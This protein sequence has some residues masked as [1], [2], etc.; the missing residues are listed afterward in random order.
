MKP[1]EELRISI[2]QAP[3]AWADKKTNLAYFS[4]E[5]ENLNATPD[6]IILPE[7][8][9]T[10]FV[11]DPAEIAEPMN[12]E[13]MQW[14]A[15]N[16]TR[17]GSVIT[18]SVAIEEDGAYYN[19][20]IWMNPDGSF[21]S[22]DKRHLF[23]MGNEHLLFNSGKQPLL[24]ELNGWKIRPLICYD[25]RFPVWSK[26]RMIKEKYEYD[27][28]IYV[29][30]WP[31][32]RGYVWKSLLIARAIENQAFCI[33][34]NRI[35]EDGKGIPHNGNSL[36]LDFKGRSLMCGPTNEPF[37]DTV[38]LDYANLASFRDRFAVGLD[39]DKFS[40]HP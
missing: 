10:A 4:Q 38:V 15:E 35:G 5:L 9:S 36:V 12:G 6:L 20:L 25:L 16:A 28:L 19:R 14:M 2:I 22:S 21:V 27:L 24:V 3:L 7:M 23:R 33:G 39:W 34:V 13:T 30:N 8:F 26:N 18:G 31:A 32:S 37:T 1:N 40:I 29:A 17:Y 11:M